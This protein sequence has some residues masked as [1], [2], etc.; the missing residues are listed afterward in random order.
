VSAPHVTAAGTCTWCGLPFTPNA[1]GRPRRYCSLECRGDAAYY[2]GVAPDIGTRIAE[3]E[4]SERA[5]DRA[6]LAVP[7]FLRNELAELRSRLP[8]RG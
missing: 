7:A 4:A 3:L 5:W 8:A 1:I 6:R 2:R